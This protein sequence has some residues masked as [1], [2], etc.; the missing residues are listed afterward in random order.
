MIP[1]LFSTVKLINNE[2]SQAKEK[3][4][5][6]EEEG[7]FNILR[8][9]TWPHIL[10]STLCALVYL[11]LLSCLFFTSKTVHDCKKI[12]HINQRS[13]AP[14]IFRLNSASSSE[15]GREP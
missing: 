11:I 1:A 15:L 14:G 12:K 6:E 3:V 2:D 10:L 4:K 5:E 9:T 13:S 8:S 7:L